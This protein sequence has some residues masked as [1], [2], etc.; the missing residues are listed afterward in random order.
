MYIYTVIV[1]FYF[2]FLSSLS[3]LIRFSLFLYSHSLL[4]SLESN[5][6]SIQIIKFFKLIINLDPKFIKPSHQRKKKEKEKEKKKE[7]E[8]LEK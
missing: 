3:S 8:C 4:S 1:T 5:N 6:K 7:R 2:F